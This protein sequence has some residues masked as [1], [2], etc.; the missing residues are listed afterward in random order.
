MVRKAILLAA[1]PIALLPVAN[2]PLVAYSVHALARA[3]IRRVAI[4]ADAFVREELEGSLE[5]ELRDRCAVQW[6]DHAPGDG[7]GRALAGLEEFIAHEPFVLHLGDSLAR[8]SLGPML[9]TAPKP[10]DATVL[11]QELA[12]GQQVVELAPRRLTALSACHAGHSEGVPAGAWVLGEDVLASAGDVPPSSSWELEIAMITGRLAE[13]G[14]RV[15]LRQVGDW[16]RYRQC[17]DSLLDANRFVLETLQGRPSEAQLGH[18]RI[19]GAVSIDPTATLESSIVRGPVVIGARVR[20]RDA[21][22]GPYTS[23]GEG[24]VIESAE[25]ENSIILPGASISH[26]GGRLEA[27]VV[28][29]NAKVFRDFSLPRALRLNVGEGAEVCLA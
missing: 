3:G 22:V 14:G 27:S 10:S 11:V 12:W 29:A 6:V 4:V 9:R 16:W 2:R 13:R 25:I 24:V 8:E 18:T 1:A 7:V 23:I 5:S 26:L 19:Q 20:L 21:Y 15:S 17:P 28:G